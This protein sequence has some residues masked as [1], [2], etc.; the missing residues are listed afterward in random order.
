MFY[1]LKHC[2]CH[3]Y[4]YNLMRYGV[5]SIMFFFS[6]KFAYVANVFDIEFSPLSM[7]FTLYGPYN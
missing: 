1:K 6:S 5:Y 7:P 2:S 3:F 4:F